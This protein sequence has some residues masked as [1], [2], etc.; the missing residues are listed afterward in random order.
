MAQT[1]RGRLGMPTPV[2]APSEIL[3]LIYNAFIASFQ[4]II[5]LRYLQDMGHFMK[6]GLQ[7]R[8]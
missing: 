7:K 8:I 6:R 4:K 5:N 3:P 1:I 2:M